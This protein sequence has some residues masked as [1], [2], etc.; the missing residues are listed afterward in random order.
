MLCTVGGGQD[1]AELAQTFARTP[2]PAGHDGVVV[3]GPFMAA[4]AR[5]VVHELAAETPRMTVL[6]FVPDLHRLIA[7]A[8][9]VVSMAGYNSVCEVLATDRPALLV[10]RTEPRTEQL[11]RA[12]RLLELGGG[13][14]AAPGPADVDR[15][16]AWTAAAVAG[17]RSHADARTA[18]DIQGLRRL[19][20]IAERLIATTATRSPRR[21]V[22]HRAA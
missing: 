22:D 17:S 3:C 6:D 20:A 5:E 21:G 10:P 12:Q 14:P 19:P 16:A 18:L 11:V 13:R 1:G 8:A 4:E 15:L 2:L 9:A 7:G